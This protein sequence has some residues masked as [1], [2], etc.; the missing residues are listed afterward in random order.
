MEIILF[1]AMQIICLRKTQGHSLEVK[2]LYKTFPIHT[3]FQGWTFE[4]LSYIEGF[5][6]THW[7]TN[8]HSNIQALTKDVMDS[9]TNY[10]I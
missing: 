9:S 8:V 5:F 1:N 6:V 3:K 7:T 2:V 10:G 4:F